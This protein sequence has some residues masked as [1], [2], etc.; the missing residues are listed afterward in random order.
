MENSWDGF[1]R[2]W[3]DANLGM[4]DDQTSAVGESAW[5][6]GYRLGHAANLRAP[7]INFGGMLHPERVEGLRESMLELIEMWFIE[8]FPRHQ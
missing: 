6:E 8:N 4:F 1:L 7:Y 5:S 3:A 2:G